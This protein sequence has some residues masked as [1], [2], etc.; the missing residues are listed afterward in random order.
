MDEKL[1]NIL[2]LGCSLHD[3]GVSNW[4][5]TKG[6]ALH[7]LELFLREGI[8]ILGGDVYIKYNEIFEPNYDS[9]FCDKNDSESEKDFLLRSIEKSISYIKKYQIPEGQKIFFIF[10]VL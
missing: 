4:A 5:F 3:V 6:E 8:A 10:T 2:K 1:Y 9:W 7:V